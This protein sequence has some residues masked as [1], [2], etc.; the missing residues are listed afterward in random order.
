MNVSSICHV[1]MLQ[2]RFKLVFVTPFLF[3]RSAEIKYLFDIVIFFQFLF[4]RAVLLVVSLIVLPTGTASDMCIFTM[5]SYTI[6]FILILCVCSG[7]ETAV[8]FL[9]MRGSLSHTELRN[10]IPVLV[11]LRLGMQY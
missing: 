6:G 2:I 10:G 3:T 4:R 5:T 11:Y 9:S 7:A 8:L 1:N